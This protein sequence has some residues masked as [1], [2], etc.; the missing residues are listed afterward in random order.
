MSQFNVAKG[1]GTNDANAV[2]A[3]V[4]PKSAKNGGYLLLPDLRATIPLRTT[5]DVGYE[6][7][8]QCYSGHLAGF[9]DLI[10][11]TLIG[12]MGFSSLR[13]TLSLGWLFEVLGS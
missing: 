5:V 7:E 6:F 3:E 9:Q 8:N 11:L 4:W 1:R 2:V 13:Y 12:I 10:S